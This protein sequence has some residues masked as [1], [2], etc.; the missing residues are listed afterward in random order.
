MC[1]CVCVYV[2]MC[3]S[4]CDQFN[5]CYYQMIEYLSTVTSS[6]VNK[7]IVWCLEPYSTRWVP[8]NVTRLK[9][10]SYVGGWLDGCV[11]DLV[12]FGR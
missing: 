3:T 10:C 11:N 12:R 2:C 1:V 8:S 9:V 5:D 6:R 4:L 7:M